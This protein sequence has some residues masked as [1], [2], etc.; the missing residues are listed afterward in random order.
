MPAHRIVARDPHR[1]QPWSD[2]SW[3]HP[4]LFA[5][6]RSDPFVSTEMNLRPNSA[7]LPETNAPSNA[8]SGVTTGPSSWSFG[9]LSTSHYQNNDAPVSEE[10]ARDHRASAVDESL[11]TTR[12]PGEARSRP[13]RGAARGGTGSADAAGDSARGRLRPGSATCWVR[14]F[15]S[16]IS[17]SAWSVTV[18]TTAHLWR[19]AGP[20]PP[21][22]RWICL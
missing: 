12:G 10:R 16:L 20:S 3:R 8:N 1:C 7:S 5:G 2:A 4:A 6:G 18:A 15:T 11:C 14:T 19:A 17:P 22:T 9:R 13:A 21:C